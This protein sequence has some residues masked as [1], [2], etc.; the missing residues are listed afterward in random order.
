MKTAHRGA[1]KKRKA[2]RIKAIILLGTGWTIREVAEALL[3]DDE[4][5]RNY[6][7]RY[8]NGGLKALLK[9]SHTGYDGKL[10]K[11]ETE[12]IDTHL[13][14]RTY[15]R[16]QDI[17]AYVDKQFKVKYSISGMTDLLHRLNYAYKKPKLVP[18]KADA[19]AQEKF[20]A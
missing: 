7:K 18:G 14:E 1:K 20:I 17:V 10:S 6:L 9:D 12:Q 3:L 13:N 15:L 2:D 11:A 19:N 4:T 5:I 16:I 8:E